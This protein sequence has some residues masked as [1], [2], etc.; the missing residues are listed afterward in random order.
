MKNLSTNIRI[1]R[2][3]P[4]DFSGNKFP[5]LEYKNNIK[6]TLSSSKILNSQ[7]VLYQFHLL[8]TMRWI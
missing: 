8:Q 4:K 2:K 3:D 7:I 1:T 5:I 6:I